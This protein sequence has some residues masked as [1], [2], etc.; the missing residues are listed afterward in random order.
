M[1]TLYMYAS[2]IETLLVLKNRTSS[3]MDRLKIERIINSFPASVLQLLTGNYSFEFKRHKMLLEIQQKVNLYNETFY[4]LSKTLSDV[5]VLRRENIDLRASNIQL[6][7][8]TSEREVV[9]A[10]NGMKLKP[11]GKEK[12]V[13]VERSDLTPPSASDSGEGSGET[14]VNHPK[15]ISIRSRGFLTGDTNQPRRLRVRTPNPGQE[16]R[17]GRLHLSSAPF[18]QRYFLFKFDFYT[19]KSQFLLNMQIN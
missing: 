8:L 14:R 5:E 2:L 7:Y 15:S 6:T 18:F 12:E 19:C 4:R 10:G 16:V 13:R 11:K 9:P 3:E 17:L 1:S